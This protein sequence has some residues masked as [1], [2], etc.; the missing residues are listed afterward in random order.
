M[1]QV[2]SQT[3]ATGPRRAAPVGMGTGG[4][5]FQKRFVS[6]QVKRYLCMTLMFILGS[7][8]PCWSTGAVPWIP[9]VPRIFG[10]IILIETY[11]Y[12]F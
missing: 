3:G 8:K 4:R 2:F 5:C 9:T 7:I 10:K 12:W 1:L 11:K 6:W